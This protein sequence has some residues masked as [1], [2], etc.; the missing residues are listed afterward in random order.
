L[1][2]KLHKRPYKQRDIAGAA[3]CST[4]PPFKIKISIFTIVKTDL[5]KYHDAGFSR[6]AVNQMWILKKNE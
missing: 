1:V 2:T 3:K 4:K 5:K 6:S